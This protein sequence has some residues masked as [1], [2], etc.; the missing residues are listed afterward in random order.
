MSFAEHHCRICGLYID[1]PPWGNDG[2]CPTYEYCPCCHV[3]FG[4]Q[5]YTVE[6]VL[7]Y[8]S[9]WIQSGAHWYNKSFK[10]VDWDLEDQLNHIP[11]K[12][13]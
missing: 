13:K 4:N 10:P 8:R 7:A 5:D 9:R 1:N 3:E 6:S 2:N 11:Q 12:F